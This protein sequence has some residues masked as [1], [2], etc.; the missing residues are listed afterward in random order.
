MGLVISKQLVEAMDGVLG[1]ESQAGRGS[2][3]WVELPSI[4]AL[5][6]KQESK[7][8]PTRSTAE[9]RASCTPVTL[10][11]VEDNASNLQVVRMVI[12]RVHPAWRFLSARNG[13]TGLQQAKE[14]LPSLILLDLQLPDLKGDA[15]L[16][17]LRQH[18]ATAHVPVMMLSADA[19]KHSR[20]RLMELGASGYLP[21]PFDVQA[22]LR[23]I[24]LMLALAR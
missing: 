16:R 8:L 22:L 12:E 18:P 1:A 6:E 2:T 3:F 9:A 5:G 24:D 23:E 14:H 11:Y 13:A 19:T 10:L 7:D 20:E 21:K 4:A 15:V 17:E